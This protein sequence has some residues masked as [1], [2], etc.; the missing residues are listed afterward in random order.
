MKGA[1]TGVEEDSDGH[2]T[3]ATRA[4]AGEIPERKEA[5]GGRR[6]KRKNT[7]NEG[8]VEGAY[9]RAGALP[10]RGRRRA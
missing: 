8:D 2:R 3:S 1:V 4:R 9:R 5:P 10:C 7:G 6:P